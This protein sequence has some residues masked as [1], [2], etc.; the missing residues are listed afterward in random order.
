[1]NCRVCGEK[2]II[3][4]VLEGKEKD[5]TTL[6]KEPYAELKRT[7]ELH[8]CPICTHMQIEWMNP[9]NYYKEYSLIS[10]ITDDSGCGM[11]TDSS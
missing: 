8:R 10:N 7:L 5:V 11:Y 4:D 2:T 6:Y 9:E 1:M 3:L